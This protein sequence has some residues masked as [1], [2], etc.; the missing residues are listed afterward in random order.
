MALARP[1]PTR[2][3]R[4]RSRAM[5]RGPLRLAPPAAPEDRVEHAAQEVLA[6]ARCDDAPPVRIALSMDRWR[7]RATRDRSAASALRSRSAARWAAAI[8]RACRSISR[9]CWAGVIP[10]EGSTV[11]DPDPV[12]PPVGTPGPAAA[13]AAA[14]AAASLA[15][16]RSCALSRSTVDPYFA[17]SGLMAI[18]PRN[19]TSSIGAISDSGAR[20]RVAAR[21]VGTPFGDST[22]TKASP[23]P[24]MSACA[25]RRRTRSSGTYGRSFGVPRH[26]PG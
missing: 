9:R 24:A 6:D 22:V 21:G 3:P 2:R 17:V 5:G 11:L 12:A 15:L 13:V 1:A 20:S 10:I 18:R 25:P 14:L 7:S 19:W 16:M 8:S 4:Q 23:V 26:R